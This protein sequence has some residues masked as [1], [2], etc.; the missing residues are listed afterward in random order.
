MTCPT[1]PTHHPFNSKAQK[2]PSKLTMHV[3][4]FPS[5]I[6]QVSEDSKKSWVRLI[7]PPQMFR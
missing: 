7:I 5:P 3:W 6:S 2:C 4:Y 1:S